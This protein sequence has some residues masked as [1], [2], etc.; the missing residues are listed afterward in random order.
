MG[1]VLVE[2][3][4]SGGDVFQE[5]ILEVNS[6]GSWHGTF[7]DGENHNRFSTVLRLTKGNYLG[8]SAKKRLRLGATGALRVG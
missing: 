8:D 2:M 7:R 1:G 4:L 6:D 5:K 3:R